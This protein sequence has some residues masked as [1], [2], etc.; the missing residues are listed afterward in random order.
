MK[1]PNTDADYTPEHAKHLDEALATAPPRDYHAL[2]AEERLPAILSLL[3]LMESS[4][5]ILRQRLGGSA[6]PY[7]GAAVRV[8]DQTL[9]AVALARKSG[10]LP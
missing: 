2:S 4:V 1:P 9:Q 10:L 8:A 7:P 3:S 6:E 5:K